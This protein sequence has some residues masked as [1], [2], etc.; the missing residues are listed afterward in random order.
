[1]IL[2]GIPKIKQ[3]TLNG[4][5]PPRSLSSITSINPIIIIPAINNEKDRLYLL[6]IE[7]A[8]KGI[9]KKADISLNPMHVSYNI[10][11]QVSVVS[12]QLLQGR[13]LLQSNSTP[14][15]S[16]SFLI[17]NQCLIKMLTIKSRPIYRG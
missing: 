14:K 15:S 2:K 11:V 13:P 7:Y 5:I 10:S 3:S 4:R 6:K 1:M 16:F 12:C 9:N 17:I 8:K